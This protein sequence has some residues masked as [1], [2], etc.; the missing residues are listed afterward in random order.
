MLTALTIRDLAIIDRLELD[1][2]PGL[3]VITGETGAGK[4]ILLDALSLCLGD[5]ADGGMVRASRE[6]AEVSAAFDLGDSAV[7]LAWLRERE[8]DDGS[9]LVL[10]RTVSA[11]GRSRGYVNGSPVPVGE[12]RALGECLIDIHS[13]HEHQTLLRKDSHREVLDA[14]ADLAPLAQ[15]VARAHRDWQ[16]AARRL[17]ELEKSGAEQAARLDFVRFQVEELDRLGL[18]EGELERIEQEYDRLAHIGTR[19]EQAGQAAA[20]LHEGED[21]H[22]ESLL[23]SALHTLHAVAGREPAL[24]EVVELV[25]SALIQTQEA[26][27]LLRHYLDGLELDPA[28]L[29]ELD[30][31]LAAIHQLARKHR[32]TPEEL[33]AHHQ[34]LLAELTALEQAQDLDGLRAEAEHLGAGYR[35]QAETLRAA[36]QQAATRLQAQIETNLHVLGM[37]HARF[38]AAFT[39][40]D[41]PAP[42]GLDDIEFQISMN[43]GQPLKPL[44]KV[45]SG[46]EL[47]RLSLAIQVENAKHAQVPA[48]V[49]DEV[50]VGIGGA[51]AEV[52]GRKLRELGDR[53]QVFCITHQPQV[54]A[55]GHQHL[56]VEKRTDGIETATTVVT[57]G[58]SD[59]VQEIARMSGGL[60][61]TTETLKHAEAML[62]GA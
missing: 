24:K 54:A 40:L 10:R 57:L 3:T 42:H 37:A 43:P 56:R 44:A 27:R 4:S 60:T 8:L 1:F 25:D 9:A 47:S 38:A 51:V 2:G 12:L 35:Q 46:G 30:Q 18:T 31:R 53:A 28:R 15:A 33:L 62:A 16:T 22:A 14:S 29:G 6:R 26:G 50:D 11:D 17:A 58:R 39:A 19:R 5:R 52:V 55:L 34:R 23:H 7:A 32:V 20:L 13:Q 61:V 36:R 59:R 21:G 49:F 41:K 48:L 45:A